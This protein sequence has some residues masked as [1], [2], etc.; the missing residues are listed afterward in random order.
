MS[1]G[2]G[3]KK[4]YVPRSREW[5]FKQR[6]QRRAQ[7]M[8]H[9]GNP[10]RVEQIAHR[11]HLYHCWKRLDSEGGKAAGVDGY[12]YREFSPVEAG[13]IVGDLSEQ[14]ISGVYFSEGVREVKIPKRPDSDKYRTL[15]IGTICDRV[16]GSALDHA[17][18]DFWKAR[19]LPW[20]YGFRPKMSPWR[21]LADL[22]VTMRKTGLRVLA[23][24]D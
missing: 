9:A 10:I 11:E 7:S 3:F 2:D 8:G 18:R 6:Q 16:L 24:D 22:E 15:K 23:V 4:P 19:F 20:S 14:V 13:Q 5:H 1:S 12:S 17:F 21:M